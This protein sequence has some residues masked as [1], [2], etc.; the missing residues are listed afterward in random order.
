MGKQ[1]T[2]LPDEQIEHSLKDN[3]IDEQAHRV[4]QV[5]KCSASQSRVRPTSFATGRFWRY[6][7]GRVRR[8]AS[9]YKVARAV[10]A[11]RE[12]GFYSAQR[13]WSRA[14][15]APRSRSVAAV[16]IRRTLFWPNIAAPSI[17]F[18]LNVAQASGWTFSRMVSASRISNSAWSHAL[19]L[20][21]VKL[22]VTSL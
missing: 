15:S 11:P 5:P 22:T 16:H 13:S 6:S 18:V 9:R 20:S 17:D 21:S 14:L 2:E 4:L 3:L 12:G 10:R 19:S 7:L 8:R 1:A